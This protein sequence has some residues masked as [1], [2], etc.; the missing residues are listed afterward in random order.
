MFKSNF[1]GLFKNIVLRSVA[2]LAL[3][4][5]TRT[6]IFTVHALPNVLC[7]KK[8]KLYYY[9][10][11]IKIGDS[12]KNESARAKTRGESVERPPPPAV[13]LGFKKLLLTSINWIIWKFV[14]EMYCM[15]VL[16]PARWTLKGPLVTPFLFRKY[17][18]GFAAKRKNRFVKISHLYE[19]FRISFAPEKCENFRFFP[20]LC[21]NL[22]QNK[23]NL[24]KRQNTDA[25]PIVFEKFFAKKI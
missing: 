2:L 17:M 11:K 12:V 7:S 20:K 18:V 4:F 14:S 5:L 9:S 13:C 24:S 19:H 1:H 16:G 25:T 22:F 15:Y 3:H 10:L 23:K 8:K 21:F 6:G